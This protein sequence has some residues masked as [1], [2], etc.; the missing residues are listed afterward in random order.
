MNI[1]PA[2]TSKLRP[3]AEAAHIGILDAS[4]YLHQSICKF[5]FEETTVICLLYIN[6]HLYRWGYICKLEAAVSRNGR[7]KRAVFV[8]DKDRFIVMGIFSQVFRLIFAALYSGT[9]AKL[10]QNGTRKSI[11]YIVLNCTLLLLT[12]GHN[13]NVTKTS[14]ICNPYT[15]IFSVFSF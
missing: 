15:I 7:Q 4:S 9:T 14:V 1:S 6:R 8:F 12:Q 11:D 5:V 2:A 13:L 10:L 3:M